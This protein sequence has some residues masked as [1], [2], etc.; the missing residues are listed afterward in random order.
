MKVDPT[1]LPEDAEFKGYADIVVQDIALKTDNVLFHKEKCYAPSTGHSYQADLPVG[2][3]GQFGPGAQAL[4]LTLH[5]GMQA[6]EPKIYEFFKHMGIQISEGEA[7]NLLN[8]VGESF[9][10]E[11]DAMYEA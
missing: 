3:V 8:K 5:F 7:T 10:A 11:K 2:Y 6:S 9:H 4:A 1:I